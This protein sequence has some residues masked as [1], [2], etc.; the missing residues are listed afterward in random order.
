MHQMRNLGF[1]KLSIEQDIKANI[2]QVIDRIERVPHNRVSADQLLCVE[3]FSIGNL[4]FGHCNDRTDGSYCR[5]QESIANA[6]RSLG[7]VSL[8]TFFPEI[9]KMLARFKLVPF[10]NK[11]KANFVTVHAYVQ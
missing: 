4:L 2:G 6:I 7:Q 10:I 1:G 5:L 8:L 9:A 11:L 3:H